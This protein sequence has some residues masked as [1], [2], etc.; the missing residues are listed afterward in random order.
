MIMSS[1]LQRA[2][3][4][5]AKTSAYMSY[6]LPMR[7]HAKQ[8]CLLSKFC[9][10]TFIVYYWNALYDQHTFPITAD[11]C[12]SIW[13]ICPLT[14]D[15]QDLGKGIMEPMILFSSWQFMNHLQSTTSV[16]A[17]YIFCVTLYIHFIRAGILT[18]GNRF[19]FHFPS[20]N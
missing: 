12:N 14:I 7:K 19:C 4:V 1:E 5:L 3:D 8:I 11:I 10:N 18:N 20:N 2:A 15:E 9:N 17:V 13:Q 6:M 16:M